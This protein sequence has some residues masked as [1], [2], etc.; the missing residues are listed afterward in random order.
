MNLNALEILQQVAASCSLG[1]P[2]SVEDET[3]AEYA[4]LFGHLNRTLHGIIAAHRW[5]QL[6]ETAS[7]DYDV[8]APS[9]DAGIGGFDIA[10]V[11]P[12]FIGFVNSYILNST[13]N[14]KWSFSSFDQYLLSNAHPLEFNKFLLKSMR[15]CFTQPL[16]NANDRFI[17][18]YKK[19]LAVI[20]HQ[21]Q[22]P[23]MKA[24]FEFN[25]DTT[26]I[27]EELLVRGTIA[28]YNK[29]KIG[30]LDYQTQSYNDYLNSLAAGN[31][32]N[33]IINEYQ[34]TA[35]A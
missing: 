23:T 8:N 29:T 33:N 5:N 32:S 27:D 1:K 20:D 25:T 2:R 28:N 21:G 30:S 14:A 12:G 22:N 17:F 35:G 10:Q 16:P 11:A 4:L 24:Y 7:F 31:A 6:I 34:E 9:Y 13:Q 18:N 19:N 15:I 26:I 3:V